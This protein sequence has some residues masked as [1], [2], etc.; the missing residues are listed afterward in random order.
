MGC[1]VDDFELIGNG[2]SWVYVAAGSSSSENDTES[3][4]VF[5]VGVG[6]RVIG[7]TNGETASGFQGPVAEVDIEET[8]V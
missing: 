8:G 2:H 1:G 4:V 3:V 5:E 6:S 7:L